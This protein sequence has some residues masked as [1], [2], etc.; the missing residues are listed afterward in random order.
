MMLLS[1]IF[2]TRVFITCIYNTRV[3]YDDVTIPYRLKDKGFSRLYSERVTF[4]FKRC[5]F[6][7]KTHYVAM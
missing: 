7:D 3:A 6:K 5:F 2:K 4:L 1:L